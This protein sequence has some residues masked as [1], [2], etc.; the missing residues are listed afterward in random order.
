M[1][2][3]VDP[4]AGH[5]S[6]PRRLNCN[7][8]ERQPPGLGAHCLSRQVEH[9]G[10]QTLQ[11][12]EDTGSIPVSDGIREDDSGS[13]S[14]TPTRQPDSGIIYHP[15]KSL[16]LLQ[17]ATKILHWAGTHVEDLT[18]VYI[19]GRQNQIANRLRHF[20]AV[21]NGQSAVTIFN[22]FSPDGGHPM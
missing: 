11:S 4:G 6:Q 9:D 12:A 14:Q 17:L 21:E 15:T 22:Q 5:A 1:D 18:A 8:P 7:Y 16:A 19:S 10:D 20:P 2:L 13:L 3:A